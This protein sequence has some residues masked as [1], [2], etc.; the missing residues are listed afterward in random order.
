MRKVS[1]KFVEKIKTHILCSLPFYENRS[2]YEIMS[3]KCGGAREAAEGNKVHLCCMATH[4][5]KHA[6]AHSHSKICNTYCFSTV[7]M[8]T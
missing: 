8:V 6:L 1:D 2:I 7:T 4:E 5:Q 3:K